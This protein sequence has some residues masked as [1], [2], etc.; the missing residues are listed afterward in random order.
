MVGHAALD[1]RI[2]VRIPVSQPFFGFVPFDDQIE[3]LSVCGVKSSVLEYAVRKY[4][5]EQFALFLQILPNIKRMGCL[6]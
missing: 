6:G 2:G 3:G 4:H 5:I 1:R